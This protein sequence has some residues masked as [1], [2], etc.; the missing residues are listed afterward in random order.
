M[1]KL[2]KSLFPI[3]CTIKIYFQKWDFDVVFNTFEKIW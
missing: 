2:D 1:I 3:S